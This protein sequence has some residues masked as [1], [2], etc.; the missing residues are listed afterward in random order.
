MA[1]LAA[2]IIDIIH[3]LFSFGILVVPLSPPDVFIPGT[4]VAG[5]IMLSLILLFNLKM[6]DE[7]AFQAAKKSEFVLWGSLVFG[8][9]SVIFA[10][11]SLFRMPAFILLEVPIIH[12]PWELIALTFFLIA[13][14]YYFKKAISPVAT[15]LQK[16]M[17]LSITVGIFV[18]L[19]MK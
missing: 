10:L 18:Q 13:F 9:S 14:M 11:F 4:W 3:G 7:T 17:I 1:F 6:G 12:R 2:G 19:I 15:P 5:R 16:M 8:I